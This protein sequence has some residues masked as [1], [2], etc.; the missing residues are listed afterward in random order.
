MSDVVCDVVCVGGEASGWPLPSCGSP[1]S[2]ALSRA[3]SAL[4]IS[5][6]RGT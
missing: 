5:I 1:L 3:R 6:N 2:I 4:F